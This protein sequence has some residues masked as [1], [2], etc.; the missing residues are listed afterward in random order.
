M[1][2]LSKS[3]PLPVIVIVAI[4]FVLEILST[5]IFVCCVE[6][7]RPH[8]VI[9]D[10][11]VR[12]LPADLLKKRIVSSPE[13][14][15]NEMKEEII[16]VYKDVRVTNLKQTAHYLTCVVFNAL[17]Y[18]AFVTGSDMIESRKGCPFDADYSDWDC[19]INSNRSKFSCQDHL[20]TP[21]NES[22]KI[23]IPM[24]D[25]FCTRINYDFVKIFVV[26]Y[27]SYNF[28]FVVLL[29]VEWLNG[30]VYK[31]YHKI[32]NCNS[33]NGSSKSSTCCSMEVIISSIILAMILLPALIILLYHE[34]GSSDA[35]TSLYY[36]Q[37]S[38]KYL[39]PV[40]NLQSGVI[41]KIKCTSDKYLEYVKLSPKNADDKNRENGNGCQSSENA[42]TEIT[43]LLKQ[44]K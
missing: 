6:E 40:C 4:L 7:V 18:A 19:V 3:I 27:V 42:N 21:A 23:E 5:Y 22:I 43:P 44:N 25:V 17:M 31:L 35:S 14:E 11:L 8:D 24:K 36:S 12:A 33:T 29:F 13:K 9:I 16:M 37:I 39:I 32:F 1:D 26:V 15:E 34:Y 2:Y 41:F 20:K 10:V 30:L 28:Y 38:A